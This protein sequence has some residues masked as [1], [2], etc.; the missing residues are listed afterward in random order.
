MANPSSTFANATELLNQYETGFAVITV[1]PHL[2]LPSV[3][4]ELPADEI[5]F[6]RA[7]MAVM[8][9]T[10]REVL[11][12]MLHFL[13]AIDDYR[14]RDELFGSSLASHL[15]S[16]SS[17]PWSDKVVETGHSTSI[18][19]DLMRISA[20]LSTIPFRVRRE[21]HFRL[22]RSFIKGFLIPQAVTR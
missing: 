21:S 14:I 4:P 6:G 1:N 9:I 17:D 15:F 13:L 2:E 10:N 12:S 7:R 19:R 5:M 11:Q 20:S 22:Y 16:G 3:N 8:D 18:Y